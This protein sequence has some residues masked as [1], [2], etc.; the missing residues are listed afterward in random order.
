MKNWGRRTWTLNMSFFKRFFLRER[1]RVLYIYAYM[2]KISV[3]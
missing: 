2:L 1:E 3:S